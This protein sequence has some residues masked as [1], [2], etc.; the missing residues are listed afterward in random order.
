MAR[1][2][3]SMIMSTSEAYQAY[4][5]AGSRLTTE[6]MHKV[7]QRGAWSHYGRIDG[8]G[9]GNVLKCES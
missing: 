1:I 5:E 2:D 9:N 7:A 4:T 6:R 8:D 3:E